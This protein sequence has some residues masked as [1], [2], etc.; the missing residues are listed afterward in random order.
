M[1]TTSTS[2][3]TLHGELGPDA[4]RVLTPDA[5][6]LVADLHRD[7][8][9]RARAAA[10]RAPGAS[11]RDR[12]GRHARTSWPR[13]GRSARATGRSPPHPDYLDRRVEI[14]G[15]TDARWSS[16]R[17]TRARRASWPTSRTRTRRPAQHDR[18]ARPTSPRRSRARSSYTEPTARS[19][20]WTTRAATLLVRP[21][22]WHLHDRH[23]QVDGEP[24][25]GSLMDFGAVPLPQLAAAARARQTGRYL[26]LPEDGEPPRGAAVERRVRCTRRTRS[27]CRAARSA[28]RCSSRRS[29]R[30]S[31]WTRSSTSCAST[32]AG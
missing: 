16:T 12:Q 23:M 15:P 32:P 19:T 31:R 6:A 10:A 11:G 9:P 18:R 17:S 30:R 7:V 29:R 13:R 28:R 25:S 26:Y 22:G 3:V 20:S 27:A 21:R 5:L 4:E 14:T 2:G 24:V 1:S 8:Q